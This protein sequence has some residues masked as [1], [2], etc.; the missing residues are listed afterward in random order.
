MQNGYFAG[1]S[2]KGAE[3][4]NGINQVAWQHS[5]GDLSIWNTDANWNYTGSSFYGS[6][7]STQ[8][9]QA[10]TNFQQDFNGDTEVGTPPAVITGLSVAEIIQQVN[11]QLQDSIFTHQELKSLLINTA[12]GGIT[13]QEFADLQLIG[14]NLA[15]YLSESSS[16]YQSYIYDAVVN[17]NSANQWWTGGNSSRISLGNMTAGSSESQANLLINKWYGGLDRPTNFVGG[18]TAAGANATSFGYGQMTGDLFVNGVSFS[19]VKQ[20]RAGT[21]YVLA[22][23]CAY[24]SNNSSI[25]TN[26]FKDN[27][28]GTYGIRFYGNDKSELWVT[29]DSYAPTQY[30]Y[31]TTLA[32]GSTSLLSGEKWVALLEKGYAQANEIGKFSRWNTSEMGQNSYACV[33]GGLNDALTHLSGNSTTTYT[34]YYGAVGNYTYSGG[35]QS[36]WNSYESNAIEAL[37]NNKSLWLGCWNNTWGSNG[38]RDFV[39]GH[40]FAITGYNSTTGD[41]S[42]T[43]PWGSNGWSHNHT[44]SAKWSELASLGL[45]PIVSWA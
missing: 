16:S 17:G 5:S 43:N 32:G 19:D 36:I 12:N 10:E 44:F 26:M 28:D 37:N 13:S 33:E 18:D 11:T 24:G 3:T 22:A 21:C 15:D 20:G 8:A 34:H 6:V 4:I 25:I 30:G 35:N 1:W 2:L 38:K 45:K 41:F 39:Q 29:V 31:E 9:Y 42:I 7:T 40:A 23:A 14:A 27:G